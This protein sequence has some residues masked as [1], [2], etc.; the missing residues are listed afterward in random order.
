MSTRYWAIIF[1][2]EQK[3]VLVAVYSISTNRAS[4]SGG[5]L[6]N[7]HLDYPTRNETIDDKE[8]KEQGLLFQ[9]WLLSE[10]LSS[11]SLVLL[12]G[13][14]TIQLPLS[15][16]RPD[17]ISKVLGDKA[18]N[19]TL[20]KCGFSKRIKLNQS[21]F[22]LGIVEN[23]KFTELLLGSVDGKF[24]VL[25]G[26]DK[27]LFLDNDTNKSIEQHT[28]KLKLSR[29]AQNEWKNYLLSLNNFSHSRKVPVCLLIAPSKE[30]VYENFYPYKFSNKAPIRT[31]SNLVPET[32]SF[33][34]PV[35]ELKSLSKRSYRVCDTHWTLHGAKEASILLTKK[36]V[37]ESID[38]HEVFKADK[39]RSREAAGDLGSKL[40]P[41]Q[42]HV[43]DNIVNFNYKQKIIFDNNIE[44]F[45]R[46]IVM[47]ND[48]AKLKKT[49]LI[50][51]SSSSYTMFH[52]LCRLFK[53][54]FFVHSAGNVDHEVIDTLKPDCICM[55]T[56]ARF[57]I[58]AP[59]FNDSVIE[60]I[61]QKK[62]ARMTTEE[63]FVS[64]SLPEGSEGYIRYFRQMLY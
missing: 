9:G 13:N 43:E 18:E 30:M 11:L 55:Q 53:T 25:E 14:E 2:K 49:L 42:R 60:Y 26:K 22:S 5:N 54:V 27:W 1:E 63:P 31:L 4:S 38:T 64:T 33:L 52:Y 40:F 57:V 10:S 56:N 47:H 32:L 28:G 16:N 15:R 59:K 6:P 39:Y 17:V 12:N 19:H 37:G 3:E 48:E 50:F 51:G 46:I 20:L 62:I 36:L 7:W 23:G 8:L 34:L 41:P 21:K 29:T 44:N 35:E 58:R 24:K 61:K 45:G